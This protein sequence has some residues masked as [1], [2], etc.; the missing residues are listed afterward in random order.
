[1]RVLAQ[2]AVADGVKR[3]TPEPADIVR[4]QRGD[5]D[6]HFP[7]GLVGEGEQENAVR[8]YA[9]LQ[10]ISHA[11]SER[12]RFARARARNH[13]RGSRRRGNGGVLLLIELARIINLQMHRRTEGL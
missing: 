11:I 8:G 10:Q 9:L 5:A 2:Q 6:E 7:R 12:A 4:Q 1:M 13:Q 3:P